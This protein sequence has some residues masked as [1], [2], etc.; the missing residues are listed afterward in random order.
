M[1]YK[2]SREKRELAKGIY[3]STA[4]CIFLTGLKMNGA[5]AE[6]IIFTSVMLLSF[7]F[8]AVNFYRKFNKEGLKS[9]SLYYVVLFTLIII[10]GVI[11]SLRDLTFNNKL[12]TLFGNPYAAFAW[13]VPVVFI[14]AHDPE[15]LLV[16]NKISITLIKIATF[17]SPVLLLVDKDLGVSSLYWL[18]CLYFVPFFT[19][20]YQKSA[21]KKWIIIGVILFLVY[22]YLDSVRTGFVQVAMHG[23]CFGLL[24]VLGLMGKGVMGKLKALLLVVTSVVLFITLMYKMDDIMASFSQQDKTDTRSFLYVEVFED[25]TKTEELTF[26]KGPLGK[27]YSDYFF[28][29]QKNAPA[30]NGDAAD[31]LTVEVGFLEMLLKGGWVMAVL[32][33]MICIPAVIQ[34][35]F[36]SKNIMARG[37]G[38]YGL[39]YLVILFILNIPMYS[40]VYIVF[41]IIM[42]LCASRKFRNIEEKSLS[43]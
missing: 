20:K 37:L 40:N 10:Y 6:K 17:A 19:W 13:L 14:Y 26:G 15:N 36:F 24:T 25:L 12:L 18:T 35:I 41:W 22:S 3:L 38:L 21:D 33:F 11:T 34:S 7:Y 9:F 30:E 32:F 4:Y 16:L 23:L 42:G 8:L 5:G 1:V 31:R 2:L 39:C 43:I 28:N 29:L 27:Y